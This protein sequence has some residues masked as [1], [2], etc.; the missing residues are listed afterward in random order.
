MVAVS[1]PVDYIT[2]GARIARVSNGDAMMPRVTAL[3]CSLNGVIGAFAVGQEPFEATVA[4][5]AYYG[6][7]G[8]LAAE[9]R[10]QGPASFALAFIDA[11]YRLSPA[12][13]TARAKVAL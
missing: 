1:G 11:L 5:L 6:L 2:D 13:L 4:A 9:T 12:T 10:P 3:G 7:A 8:E